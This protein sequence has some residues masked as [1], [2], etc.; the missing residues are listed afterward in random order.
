MIHF[1]K[2][3][4]YDVMTWDVM[5]LCH[6]V[7]RTSKMKMTSKLDG[8]KNED[9]LIYALKPWDCARLL[10]YHESYILS[11]GKMTKF[12][13]F[14]QKGSKKAILRKKMRWWCK[15]SFYLSYL[16]ALKMWN[17]LKYPIL[18]PTL[19]FCNEVTGHNGKQYWVDNYFLCQWN[20]S[21]TKIKVKKKKDIKK[22]THK[23]K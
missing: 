13:H 8:L 14:P 7:M 2:R 22:V 6:D 10:E 1:Y 3:D 19:L 12:V 20:I 11:G 17:Q 4:C 9:D 16:R 23:N 5:I 18:Q 21:G 15:R